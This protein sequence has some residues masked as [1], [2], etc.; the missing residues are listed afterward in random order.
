[1]YPLLTLLR[2]SKPVSYAPIHV[3][4]NQKLELVNLH[5]I[6]KPAFDCMAQESSSVSS[7]VVRGRLPPCLMN[8]SVTLRNLIAKLDTFKVIIIARDDDDDAE[9]RGD[10]NTEEEDF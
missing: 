7:L 10:E 5:M 9:D 8:D 6:G 1:M 4:F 3:F 2:L